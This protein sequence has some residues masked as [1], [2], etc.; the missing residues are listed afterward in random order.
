[1]L[2]HVGPI[3][4]VSGGQ[5]AACEAEVHRFRDVLSSFQS[6]QGTR[7]KRIHIYMSIYTIGCIKMAFEQKRGPFSGSMLVRASVKL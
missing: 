7:N 2:G 1:M 5:R 4:D 6:Q 3:L